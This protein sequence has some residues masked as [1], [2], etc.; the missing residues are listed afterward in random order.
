MTPHSEGQKKP[1]QTKREQ[2]H[3]DRFIH[4]EDYATILG[5]G[6]ETKSLQRITED[7]VTLARTRTHSHAL[8]HTSLPL[9]GTD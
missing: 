4:T 2:W 6:A 9:S 1:K 5:K 7:C 3:R 8:V